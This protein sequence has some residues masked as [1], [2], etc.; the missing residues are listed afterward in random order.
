AFTGKDAPANV[1]YAL[2]TKGDFAVKA[3]AGNAITLTAMKTPLA[4]SNKVKMLIVPANSYYI[5]EF[6]GKTGDDLK[7]LIEKYGVEVSTT[8][9]AKEK[10]STTGKIKVDS[11]KAS[12][13]FKATELNKDYE[14]VEK[15]GSYI[16]KVPYATTVDNAPATFTAT[17]ED[18]L[19]AKL[20]KVTAADNEIT[21]KLS[22][23]E[24]ASAVAAGKVKYSE[25][26]KLAKRTV[27]VKLTAEGYADE[28]VKLNLTLPEKAKTYAEVKDDV[29]AAVKELT[30]GKY[31][32]K[33][34]TKT[35]QANAEL[36][37]DAVK[38]VVPVDSDTDY[39]AAY[40]DTTYTAPTKAEAGSIQIKVALTDKTAE[41]PT[42]VDVAKVTLTIGKLDTTV[43]DFVVK[44]LEFISYYD[45]NKLASNS[46]TAESLLAAAREYV[47]ADQ[48]PEFRVMLTNFV[49]TE[50][51]KDESGS[52]SYEFKVKET[53][54]GDVQT[55][56]S[57]SFT[58]N[59]L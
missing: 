28:T 44:V 52:I 50:A 58:I 36:V 21:V 12:Q 34:E 14:I 53:T 2:V 32:A 54:T 17:I 45:S 16:V 35:Q 6:D 24:L 3:V 20:F 57:G 39:S 25:G 43:A 59:Q 11:K 30:T 26:K 10:A 48:Y 37:A 33:S 13:T 1:S 42:P 51:T 56:G 38:A 41:A 31:D 47:K 15:K 27:N 8:I 46:T 29:K 22:K 4:K 40:V 9:T 18:E 23:A 7:K 55:V 5:D 49:K 19:N